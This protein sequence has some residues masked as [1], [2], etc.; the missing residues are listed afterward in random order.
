MLTLITTPP[1]EPDPELEQFLCDLALR[2]AFR[3]MEGFD[4]VW[5]AANRVCDRYEK[6][7]AA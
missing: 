5:E 4:E 1:Q 7:Q 3:G 6:S 2:L